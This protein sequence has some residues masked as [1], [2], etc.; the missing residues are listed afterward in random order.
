MRRRIVPVVFLGSLLAIVACGG[1]EEPPPSPHPKVD[2]FA[3]SSAR[4]APPP[5]T[6]QP[7]PDSRQAPPELPEPP[8]TRSPSHSSPEPVPIPADVI[9]AAQAKIQKLHAHYV[10]RA[11]PEA[12]RA[13][14]ALLI[15]DR[16]A[17]PQDIAWL[18][19]LPSRPL[20]AG[21]WIETDEIAQAIPTLE[22]KL[23]EELP[24][25]RLQLV[26]GQVIDC[27]IIQQGSEYVTIDRRLKGAQWT[28]V[29][30]RQVVASSTVGSGLHQEATQKLH[31]ARVMQ[32]V[33]ELLALVTWARDRKLR[34]LPLLAFHLIV[35]ID[36]SHVEARAAIGR[37]PFGTSPTPP[38][39]PTVT[40][41]NRAWPATELR[42]KLI[43]DGYVVID[44]R[45]HARRERK[46]SLPGLPR[47]EA[48]QKH[49]L[50]AIG[51]IVG[52]Y[53]STWRLKQDPQKNLFDETEDRQY[54]QR[55][56]A[57][58]MNVTTT[59]AKSGALPNLKI[60]KRDTVLPVQRE[61]QSLSAEVSI[62]MKLDAPILEARVKSIAEVDEGSITCMLEIDGGRIE[63]CKCGKRENESRPIPAV[64]AGDREITL[65]YEIRQI[66]K[67]KSGAETRHP[68]RG[69]EV[70][71]DLLIPQYTARLFPSH[72]NSMSV[73]QATIVVAELAAG[74][75]SAFEKAGALSV[76]KN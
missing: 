57:V 25:D 42:D 63:I 1:A 19:A 69:I 29:Y 51:T 23:V 32:S 16:R 48:Q 28:L 24:K 58:P 60:R 13:R 12:D 14:M 3:S 2:P 8:D 38:E 61:G 75:N 7:V 37:P 31:R 27:R 30:R 22:S 35:K 73:F 20:I 56:F 64:V 17:I 71:H 39:T 6:E 62:P 74:L 40:W 47:Y 65:I 68:T 59:V 26:G 55:F 43:K 66:A 36:P 15:R 70:T 49:A 18:R 21:A 34:H 52:D 10:E 5:S 9:L 4:P 45:W 41:E 76:L 44:G 33:P 72:E 46:L 53:E 50:E 11:L 67:Y 54:S